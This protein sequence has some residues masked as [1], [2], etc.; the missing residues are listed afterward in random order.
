LLARGARVAPPR[1]YFTGDHLGYPPADAFERLAA[2]AN[3][4][5]DPAGR[6][7]FS[8][9]GRRPLTGSRWRE[10][11][12]K[13]RCLFGI[14]NVWTVPPVNGEERIKRGGVPVH[15]NQK[16]LELT[17]LLLRASSDPGDTVWEPLGGCARPRSPRS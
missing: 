4:H 7:Y 8:A 9:D 2:Y 14:T 11:R 16:P 12:A 1:K 10:L 13:F 17:T 15:A 3:R 6:P 5:G